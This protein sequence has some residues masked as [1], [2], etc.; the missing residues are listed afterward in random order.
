MTPKQLSRT[1]WPKDFP[2]LRRYGR[3]GDGGYV[4]PATAFLRAD[5]LLSFG[6][7]FDWTFE[8]EF[9]AAHAAAPIHAYDP[10][11]GKTRF[12]WAG[13][14]SLLG[15]VYS[16]REWE[17]FRACCDYFR[18]FKPPVVHFRE[19]IGFGPGRMGLAAAAARMPEAGALALKV[20]IEGSEYEI[21]DEIVGLADRTEF[22]AIEL[23]DVEAHADQIADF[24]D[25]MS[26]T[27]VVAHLH[28]NNYAPPC[29]DGSMPGSIEVVYA[30]RPPASVNDYAGTLPR[31]GLD[32][33][34]DGK[35]PDSVIRRA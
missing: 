32:W 14:W 4:L 20:D 7:H 29:T 11:V 30:R 12:I 13:L 25:R 3:H 33:P 6:I 27:H 19:W 18:F 34:N 9:A 24:T 8:R 21:F 35:R 10:T 16:R 15:S 2:D 26:A 22:L 5:G 17:K 31:V 1:L 23:H 28:G